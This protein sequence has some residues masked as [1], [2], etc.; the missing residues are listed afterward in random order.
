MRVHWSATG[1][2]LVGRPELIA[3]GDRN[4]EDAIRYSRSFLRKGM[5]WNRNACLFVNG[6]ARPALALDAIDPSDVEAVE[7]YGLNG[8]WTGTLE[9]Q[10]IPG[11][12]CQSGEDILGPDQRKFG[13]QPKGV[14]SRRGRWDP[15]VRA[16]VIWLRQ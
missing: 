4:L 15:Y 8:D 13:L 12:R 16:I 2:A 11:K 5:V 9:Q 6:I 7:V 3:R 10:W 14:T 1:S